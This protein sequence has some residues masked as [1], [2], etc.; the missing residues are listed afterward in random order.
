MAFKVVDRL[1]REN[2]YGEGA[3]WYTDDMATGTETVEEHLVSGHGL[4]AADVAALGGLSA[5]HSEH[6][7]LHEVNGD[8]EF[9]AI[10]ERFLA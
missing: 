9:L 7:R 1:G 8:E 10:M 6:D 2:Y 5:C 4:S 3:H